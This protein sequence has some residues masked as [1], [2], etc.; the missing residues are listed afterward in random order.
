MKNCKNIIRNALY[1]ALIVSSG[2]AVTSCDDML[3]TKPNGAF[4]SE[5]IGDKEAVELMTAAYAG[6]LNHFI[7]NNEAFAGPIT[8]WVWDVRSDDAV[9]GGEVP[10]ME[11]YI[12]QLEV[13]NVQ[14]DN[15]SGSAKWLNCYYAISRC[16]TAIKGIQNSSLLSDTEKASMLGEMKTLRAFF[17]FEIYRI[18]QKFPYITENDDPSTVSASKYTREEI[19]GFIVDD[20]KQSFEDMQPV[21]DDK[22]R[23]NKYVAAGLLARVGLFIHDYELTEKYANEILSNKAQY[24][25]Y[26]NFLDISKVEF[27]NGR[28]SV[29]AIQFNTTNAPAQL[30]YSNCIT[31]TVSRTVDGDPLNYYGNGDDF[32]LASQDLVNA[33]RTDN[34]GL[35]FFDGAHNSENVDKADYDGN[36][37]PRLDFTVGRIGMPWRSYQYT[38]GW[39]RA[40]Q[41]YGQYS[42]KKPFPSPDDPSVWS[43]DAPWGA[44][45]LNFMLIRVADVMLMKAEALIEQGKDLEEAR[46]LINQ[47]RRRAARSVDPYYLPVD[48]DPNTAN[49]YIGEYP[50]AGWNQDYARKALRMERRLELA[51]EGQRW[52]DLVRWGEAVSTMNKYYAF[53]KQFQPYYEGASLSE[54]DIYMPIPLDQADKA[55]DL[56]K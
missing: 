45:N 1:A 26:D 39:C 56:Y 21:L 22:G 46:D 44:S 30:N 51:M 52:F 19:A 4:T 40:L 37:D 2:A 3:D 32:Y 36:V 14:S 31:C 8:N 18:F 10:S 5:Q 6:L 42:G 48:C 28:E 55:G 9:K 54:A 17:N 7:G 11:V 35:P 25:L 23:F 49:Y 34:M 16:N 38:S 12:H 13:G 29:M 33:F 53:E 47:I 15:A 27:N 20:L 43:V 41:L 24:G 50:A